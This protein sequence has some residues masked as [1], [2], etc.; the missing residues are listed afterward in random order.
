MSCAKSALAAFG[1]SA[2]A[3][4]GVDEAGESLLTPSPDDDPDGVAAQVP[5][6]GFVAAQLWLFCHKLRQLRI[7]HIGVVFAGFSLFASRMW[8]PV[9]WGSLPARALSCLPAAG[10]LGRR[11]ESRVAVTAHAFGVVMLLAVVL[12]LDA[13]TRKAYPRLHR[14]TGA[15][16]SRRGSAPARAALAALVV[17]RRS[18][19]QGDPLMAAFIDSATVTWLAVTAYGVDAIVRRRDE[20]AHSRAMVLSGARRAAHPAA[21]AQRA[22]ARR[23][24]WRRA[25]SPACSAGARRRGARWGAP[26]GRSHRCSPRRRR[27]RP[28][29]ASTRAPPAVFSPDG[30]AASAMVGW[31]GAG[32]GWGRGRPRPTPTT[33]PTPPPPR[34]TA[35]PPTGQIRR[36]RTGRLRRSAV[37]RCCSCSAPPPSPRSP[38]RRARLL[39]RDDAALRAACCADV[40]RSPSGA[41]AAD[42]SYT[43]AM[44]APPHAQHAPRDAEVRAMARKPRVVHQLASYRRP[45]ATS[46]RAARRVGIARAVLLASGRAARCRA[47]AARACRRAARGGTRRRR[48]VAPR[49]RSPG[50]CAAHRPRVGRGHAAMGGGVRRHRPA[51]P[52]SSGTPH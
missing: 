10:A 26:G 23:A 20:T 43:P 41:H 33:T 36:V 50:L 15:S 24:R 37:R 42:H 21:A 2:M 39:G 7:H 8:L 13:R 52:D 51:R 18:A 28:A 16:T 14:W 44:H 6:D 27:S 9:T 5:P 47:R 30:C 48:P 35:P 25:A 49:H 34:P 12:Q 3:G 22:A 1:G 11:A 32:R 45:R 31:V 40:G 4:D 38:A 29:S 19:R 46:P 17:G